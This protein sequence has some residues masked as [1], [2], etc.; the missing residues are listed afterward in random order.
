MFESRS[1]ASRFF[2]N[3]SRHL[4]PGG[5]YIAT[6]VDCR[7]VVDAVYRRRFGPAWIVADGSRGFFDRDQAD[8]RP[9]GDGHAFD[10]SPRTVAVTNGEGKPVMK[11]EF[12]ELNWNRLINSSRDEFSG[13]SLR[14]GND[15][16]A[17]GIK[18]N[19]SLDDGIPHSDES[20]AV[21]APEWLVPLGAPL[22]NLVKEHGLELVLCQNFQGFTKSA[23]MNPNLSEARFV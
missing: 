22:M 6:T 7:C 10:L 11:I 23:L 1:K 5:V 3:I 13:G 9:G 15:E 18:Y 8:I 12:D 19:F 4:R 16:D 14:D 17:F 2:Q 21:N 20:L